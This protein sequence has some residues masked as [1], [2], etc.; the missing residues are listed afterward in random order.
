L[1]I[2]VRVG[3]RVRCRR[4]VYASTIEGYIRD[5]LTCI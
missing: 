3:F 5:R 4:R 2:W 1:R